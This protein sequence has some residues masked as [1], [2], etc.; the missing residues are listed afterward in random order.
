[1]NDDFAYATRTG[2]FQ[3]IQS[4]WQVLNIQSL[5]ALMKIECR[6]EFS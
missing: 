5:I 6:G 3:K 1:L 4:F 2:Q